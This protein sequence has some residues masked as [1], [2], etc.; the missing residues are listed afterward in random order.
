MIEMTTNSST[1]VN[2]FLLFMI[3]N[4]LCGL[5]RGFLTVSSS[6]S[7]TIHLTY[8]KTASAVPNDTLTQSERAMKE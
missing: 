3:G 6:N 7:G 4:P 2:A 5:P 8:G 1:R